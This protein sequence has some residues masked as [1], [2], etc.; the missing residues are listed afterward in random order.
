MGRDPW[1]RYLDGYHGANAG[2]TE[3]AFAHAA[4]PAV[5]SAYD[6]LLSAVPGPYGDVLDVAC[7]S[8]PLHPLLDGASSYLGVDL[9]PAELASAR[10]R[11]RGPVVVGDARHL[12][13]AD[14]SVDT[15]VSSMGLMLVLPLAAALDEIA[16]VLRPGGRA[17]FLL[18]A[19]GPLRL[20][21]VPPLLVLARWLHGPGSMPQRVGHRRLAHGL[22]DVGMTVQ[23][24][25]R[26]RFG[27]PLRSAEDAG[28]ALRALYTPGRSAAQLASAERALTRLARP[29]RELPVPLLR[30]V[31]RRTG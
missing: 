22:R 6:W 10:A 15:V 1:D 29:G 5:G 23:T 17:A 12:P 18:P 24:R 13:V 20:R 28:L 26:H 4:D 3:R 2:I 11:G 16:R 8:A 19:G 14:R 9:S 27:F 30:V 7:G 21:D 31:A 25:S